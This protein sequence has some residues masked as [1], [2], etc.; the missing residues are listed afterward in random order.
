MIVLISV[1]LGTSVLAQ[2]PFSLPT[3]IQ[4]HYENDTILEEYGTLTPTGN[5]SI[6]IDP[7]LNVNFIKGVQFKMVVDSI[8]LGGAASVNVGDTLLIPV[9]FQLFTGS[10]GFHVIIEGTPEIA[11]ES[12]L[13]D[14]GLNF[15][16][17]LDY[18]VVITPE[19]YD[20]CFVDHI[21]GIRKFPHPE[22]VNLFPNPA[23][24][25]ITIKVSHQT[26]GSGFIL[27]DIMGRQMLYGELTDESTVLDISHLDQG[28]YFLIIDDK[29]SIL[30]NKIVVQ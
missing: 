27:V 3:Y 7:E 30:T 12:Y 28:V 19:S 9:S 2:F 17:G 15:T 20:S 13:C 29:Q 24:E 23:S 18:G 11:G 22:T 6:S 14:L 1:L 10:I 21:E 4:G 16:T 25:L 5:A 26:I 8:S